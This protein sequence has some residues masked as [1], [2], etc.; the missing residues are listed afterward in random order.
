MIRGP[1]SREPGWHGDWVIV[2][3]LVRDRDH[4]SDAVEPDPAVANRRPRRGRR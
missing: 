4:R 1:V 3:A 2:G